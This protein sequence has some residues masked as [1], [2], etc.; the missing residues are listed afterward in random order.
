MTTTAHRTRADVLDD[1]VYYNH[2]AKRYTRAHDDWP[3]AHAILN[4]LLTEL[5]ALA[6]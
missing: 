6:A 5:E 4:D 3:L 2:R 1:L